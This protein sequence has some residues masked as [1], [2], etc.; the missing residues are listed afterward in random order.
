MP[1]AADLLSDPDIAQAYEDVR[2]DKSPL[3]WLVLKYATTS[4]DNLTLAATG[5]GDI[6]EMAETL[7]DDE[8][9]Y[10]YVRMK[11]G[12]DEYSERT[13]FVFVVW[14]GEFLLLSSHSFFGGPRA[15]EVGDV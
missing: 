15:G 5:E 13:K 7:G 8:A 11:V 3:T 6:A 4:S 10:A 14:A 2:S 1:Q 12:N 9:A